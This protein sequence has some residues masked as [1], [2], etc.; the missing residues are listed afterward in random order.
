M[1]AVGD[2]FVATV[3]IPTSTKIDYGFLTT[4]NKANSAVAIW[5]GN[6]PADY[7]TVAESA[8]TVE[9]PAAPGLS[10][11]L[12]DSGKDSGPLVTQTI[13]YHAIGV[14]QAWFVWGVNGWQ[15]TPEDSRPPGTTIRRG[16]M[17]T[18]MVFEKGAFVITIR[19]PRATTLNY[20]FLT[21][22]GHMKFWQDNAGEDYRKSIETDGVTDVKSTVTVP[23]EESMGNRIT[24]IAWWPYALAAAIAV[25]GGT[26]LLALRHLSLRQSVRVIAVN[27]TLLLFGLLGIELIFGR[28]INP[29]ALHLLNVPRN[30]E[31]SFDVS[32]L[33]SSPKHITYRRDQY[34]LRG[35]FDDPSSIDILTIGGSTTD[36]RSLDEGSTWQDVL[37]KEFSSHGKKVSVVNAGIDG[38]STHG[39]IKNFD[40]W[41]PQ[42]PNL[43]V[44]YFLFYL[45]V[46]DFW[47]DPENTFDTIQ[48]TA[49]Y[50][51]SQALKPALEDR[52]ALYYLYRTIKGMF[53]ARLVFRLDHHRVDWE[54]VRYVDQATMSDHEAFMRNQI[55]AYQERLRELVQRTSQLGATPIF[56]TQLYWPHKYRN[57][58]I[59]GPSRLPSYRGVAI[60]GVDRYRIMGLFNQATMKVCAESRGICINLAE[61]L[62]FADEDFYD[63][64]H[65]TPEG[66]KKIGRYL[67]IKLKDVLILD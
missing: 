35:R 7:S 43:R 20:G 31:L 47:T 6:G 56:V 54:K 44:R 16:V 9:I 64:A 46:N 22:V 26:I 17:H 34:G 55:A 51:P 10:P 62:V 4:K 37:R 12:F 39:H 3:T 65:N 32:H 24:W 58:T 29:S 30:V 5:Q 13:R 50:S 2:V 52:S 15:Q 36:Q 60:N 8:G 18:P 40:L 14:D 11:S 57:G 61:E 45:G 66:A 28:W 21:A 53:V 1:A 38:Q 49:Y 41:F 48:G 25:A 23:D 67:Y 59:L 33:Y 63:G 42:I 27:L 19:V